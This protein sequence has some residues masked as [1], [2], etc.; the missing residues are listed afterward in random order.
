MDLKQTTGNGNAG[1]TLGMAP[2]RRWLMGRARREVVLPIM[3]L[4]LVF[5]SLWSAVP[6]A[7]AKVDQTPL[8]VVVDTDTGVDDAAAIAWLLSQTERPVELLGFAAVAGNT[9]VNNAANNVL[10]LLDAAGQPNIPVIIGADRPLSRPLSQLGALLH[11]PDGLWFAGLRH[12]HD[13]SRLPRD[14]PAFYRDLA[15]AHPG[16]TLIALGP[17]TNLARTLE[18]YPAA[19]HR[20]GRI[21]VLGGG[22]IGGN[23]T[24]VA[25]TNIFIDPEAAQSVL[26][27]GLPLTMVTLDGFAEVT[28]SEG[29]IARL[30]QS[31]L[32]V[33]RLISGP[34]ETYRQILTL[35]AVGQDVSVPDVAAAMYAVDPTRG[36]EQSA[37]V[38][39]ITDSRLARGQ[40]VIGVTFTERITMI[41]SDWELSRLADRALSDP[42]F[43]LGAEIGSILAREP[44]NAGVVLNVD[45]NEMQ[46]RLVRALA[47]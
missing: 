36:D 1:R 33:S 5:G 3:L 4:A 21:I 47:R 25:E 11:G 30:G 16:A 32:P 26:A 17:L 24:P 6:D 37:L 9:S 14:V 12:P 2:V 18:R 20:F 19:L 15:Q 46:R 45:G 7:R 23:R 31:R 39:V 35:G 28:V 8:A 10:T 34:L 41:A 38:K 43:D 22:K 44:D 13:L 40:T 42:T 27:A 29:D